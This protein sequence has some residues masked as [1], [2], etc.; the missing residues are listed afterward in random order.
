MKYSFKLNEIKQRE[1]LQS[2]HSIWVNNTRTLYYLK[3]V[4]GLGCSLGDF[5][6]P[7]TRFQCQRS[8]VWT[9]HHPAF[10]SKTT[11]LCSSRCPCAHDE[12]RPMAST[13]GPLVA[14]VVCVCVCFCFGCFVLLA[15]CS[16]E[17]CCYA[18]ILLPCYISSCVIFSLIWIHGLS[19]VEFVQ[20]T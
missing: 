15:S 2:L 11:S 12:K 4:L 5:R 1:S 17:L 8:V 6:I 16:P 20:V 9:K 18:A 10:G 13:G 7:F 14:G 3:F 19:S